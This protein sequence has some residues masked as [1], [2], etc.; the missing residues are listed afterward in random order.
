LLHMQIHL[1]ITGPSRM[2]A[3]VLLFL[4]PV[5]T[6]VATLIHWYINIK[7]S[8]EESLILAKKGFQIAA[9]FAHFVWQGFCI[10][11]GFEQRFGLPLRFTMVGLANDLVGDGVMRRNIDQWLGR[12]GRKQADLPVALKNRL[13]P[14]EKCLRVEA[15]IQ[16]M[17]KEWKEGTYSKD[18]ADLLKLKF[19]RLQA[20]L[21][22]LLGP[23]DIERISS[24]VSVG[25]SETR[26]VTDKVWVRMKAD[27]GVASASYYL[28]ST[29]GEIR[30]DDHQVTN[31]AH[32]VGVGSEEEH[33]IQ[34]ELSEFSKFVR[35]FQDAVVNRS[36][37]N[38]ESESN[39]KSKR[40]RHQKKRRLQ[41]QEGSTQAWAIFRQAAAMVMVVWVVGCVWILVH[42]YDP[43]LTGDN[44]TMT[45]MDES[46]PHIK[47]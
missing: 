16:R 5:C 9:F 4:V 11:Q 37:T 32:D 45:Q 1:K 43:T 18:K 19:S 24:N 7:D 38:S 22:E 30:V 42:V 29:T 44:P 34:S 36:N 2:L 47:T 8:H 40:I 10:Y 17:F 23:K 46:R 3:T 13:S 35:E 26:S 14:E 21:R 31:E 41:P 15:K 20:R 33:L 25:Q 39:Q 12:L 28:N 27:E 6:V